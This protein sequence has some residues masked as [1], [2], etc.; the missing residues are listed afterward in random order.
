[1]LQAISSPSPSWRQAT[2]LWALWILVL[3]FRTTYHSR[4]QDGRAVASCVLPMSARY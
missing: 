3:V 4:R 1:M 2:E